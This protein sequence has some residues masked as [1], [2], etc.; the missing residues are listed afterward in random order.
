MRIDYKPKGTAGYTCR[1]TGDAGLAVTVSWIG[2]VADV[3]VA[4]EGLPT[5]AAV[6]A[7]QQ[8]A[9]HEYQRRRT[10]DAQNREHHARE[11]TKWRKAAEDIGALLGELTDAT[12][13]GWC[14]DC[15]AKSD[16]RLA[17]SR[18]KLR[19]RRYVCT[20]C[21]SPTGRC[22]IPRCR[23]FADRGGGPGERTRFCAEHRHEIPSFEKLEAQVDSLDAYLPWLEFER[24]NAKR[25]STIAAVSVAGV[26][27]VGPLAFVAAPAIGGALGAWTGLSGA[28]ATSHG[29]ALLGGGAITASGYGMAGGVVVVTAAGAGLGG[30]SG[31]SV[32]NAYVRSDKSFGFEK[33]SDGGPET[34]IFADGFLSEGKSGW[35]AWERIVGEKYPDATVYRLSWGAKELKSLNAFLTPAVARLPAAKAAAALA[36]QAAKTAGKRLGPL[37]AVFNGASLAKN[38]WHVARTRASMTGAVLADAIVRAD[39]DSVVLIGFSLGARVMTATAE[40]LATRHE[41][42]PRVQSMHLLGAAVESRWDWRSVE[43]AVEGTIHNY[44]STNDKVLGAAF[45][46]AE[47]GKKAIGCEGIPTTSRKVKNVNVS[48]VVRVHQDQLKA[49]SLC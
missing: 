31:A 49:V 15:L 42:H 6:G 25:F 4:P 37:S 11:A 30:A 14:S 34:V 10:R 35:G 1:L 32:A 48:K 13:H 20:E 26:A 39:L 2:G 29:L 18:T 22:D 9:G 17:R 44:F 5:Q 12:E 43:P 27:V 24:F 45:R 21:G 8:F 46:V 23:N 36:A 47:A 40:S 3:E 28:A 19:T 38:P 33:V 7:V 16:H 41:P